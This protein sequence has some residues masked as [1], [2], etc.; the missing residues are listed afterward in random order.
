MR[1]RKFA[2]RPATIISFVALVVALGGSAY[3]ASK[4]DT[5]DIANNAVTAKQ[6]ENGSLKGKDFKDGGLKGKHLKDGK[7]G[8]AKLSDEAI[9]ALTPRWLL[10]N[11]NGEIEEQS[12]GFTVIDAYTT[13]D[14]VYIDAGS[15]LVDKGL[16]ATV[17]LQNKLE[18]DAAPGAD[19][20][21]DGQISVA[22]CQ[23]AAVECAPEGAKNENAFVVSPRQDDGTVTGPNNRERF[24][25][26]ITP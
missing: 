13:N 26:Q 1:M 17:A 20:S 9:D 21:F 12:G 11:E 6:V 10:V 16:T 3:A 7:I 14:N 24:Y 22:R 18:I 8:L 15:S 2:P 25:V 19:P 4:I 5:N 23:T